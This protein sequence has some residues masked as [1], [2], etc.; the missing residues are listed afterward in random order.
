M[1]CDPL[2][3][4]L[5]AALAKP[6]PDRRVSATRNHA[7][8]VVVQSAFGEPDSVQL[9]NR[10]SDRRIDLGTSVLVDFGPPDAVPESIDVL[11]NLLL[12]SWDCHEWCS[13][14]ATILDARG[15]D[16]GGL[17][18][19]IRRAKSRGVSRIGASIFAAG[20]DRYLV[21]GLFGEA[22]LI[23]RGRVVARTE[24]VSSNWGPG[25]VDVQV[26]P[27]PDGKMDVMWCRNGA[28]HLTSVELLEQKGGWE[29]EF[30]DHL[31]LPS[32]RGAMSS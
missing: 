10:V 16:I 19:E 30:E 15:R 24:L 25:A 2:G 14:E 12:V 7:A 8:I 4:R 13:S 18:L 27:S 11:G 17:P 29:F 21:F 31:A 22:A 26:L 23:V 28:C 6:D 32:C 5:R 1:R 3:P 20:K 9:W